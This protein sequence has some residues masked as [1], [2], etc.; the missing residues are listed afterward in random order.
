MLKGRGIV[1]GEL[2]WDMSEG[3]MSRGCNIRIRLL[4]VEVTIVE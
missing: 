1:Y 3:N 4:L 2:L